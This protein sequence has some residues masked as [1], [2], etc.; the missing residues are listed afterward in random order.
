MNRDEKQVEVM[1]QW[2]H[3]KQYGAESN[4]I[5]TLNLPT[6]FGKTYVSCKIINKVL[7][8][9][10]GIALILVPTNAL[11]EQWGLETR[12]LCKEYLDRIKVCTVQYYLLHKLYM[13]P[14]LLIIDELDEFYSEERIKVITKKY[15]NYTYALGLTATYEERRKR[16]L[17]VD[18]YLPIVSV[19]TEREALDNGWISKFVEFNLG[20]ELSEQEREEYT[21]LTTI[22]AKEMGKFN[23]FN[24]A[25]KVLRGNYETRESSFEIALKVAISRGWRRNLDMYKENEREIEELWNP[26]LI[27]GYAKI[28]VDAVRRRNDLIN[29]ASGKFSTTL[30]IIQKYEGVKTIT[31]SQSTPFADKLHYLINEKFKKESD[32]FGNTTYEYATI[33]HSNLGK[34]LLFDGM[35]NKSISMGVDRQR[36][37]AIE[38]IKKG[39]AS[40][41]VTARALDKGFDVKD[42][43]LAIITSGSKN[44][45]QHKQRVGRAK[46]IEDI[47]YENPV[48]IVNV[49]CKDTKEESDLIERQKL[50]TSKAYWINS[51]DKIV[52]EPTQGKIKIL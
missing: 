36:R 16:H 35:K 44:Y 33:Y 40:C 29:L 39:I 20:I 17:T 48:I 26:K 1:Y 18:K 49:Y 21:N 28:L 9:R 7:N 2:Q 31:F 11:E 42:I 43:R 51:I 22:V 23:D 4:G 50:S 30:D 6:G 45:N 15:C 14:L 19:I 8:K 46:R 10:E 32:L 3:S 37:R 34:K 25:L 5:G 47:P 27:I 52:Y 38:L 41:I 12:K 24:L 13:N